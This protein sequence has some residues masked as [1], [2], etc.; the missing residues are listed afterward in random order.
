MAR[1]IGRP[2]ATPEQARQMQKI[3]VAYKTA[4]KTLHNLGSPPNRESDQD[5]LA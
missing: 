2:I 1:E 3:G 4:E 5:T